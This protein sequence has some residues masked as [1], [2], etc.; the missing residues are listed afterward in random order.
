M[1]PHWHFGNSVCCLQLLL[2]IKPS[3]ALVSLPPDLLDRAE[4]QLLPSKVVVW[5]SAEGGAACACPYTD[6]LNRRVRLWNKPQG[7]WN[8]S[9]H[10]ANWEFKKYKIPLDMHN[11]TVAVENNKSKH[12]K[13][14]TK[15][16]SINKAVV[17]IIINTMHDLHIFMFLVVWLTYWSVY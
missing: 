6:S 12:H 11:F 9:R 7:N 13:N 4:K 3:S 1:K 5:K 16:I 8:V 15:S 2:G 14:L 10:G 17:S